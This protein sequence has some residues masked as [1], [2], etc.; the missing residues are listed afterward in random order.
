MPRTGWPNQQAA[1]PLLKKTSLDFELLGELA[2]RHKAQRLV[3]MQA[4]THQFELG[5]VSTENRGLKI[6][7]I[8]FAPLHQV[9]ED[10]STPAKWLKRHLSPRKNI[11]NIMASLAYL[12]PQQKS[13]IC[14]LMCG[15]V[16]TGYEDVL[17][18][19]M[20]KA[21]KTELEIVFI[22]I[23]IFSMPFPRMKFSK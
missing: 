18:I 9:Y 7:A 10:E 5:R 17:T 21:E 3:L 23:P 15:E 4:D 14:I 2:S 19:T 16:E 22:K 13:Q 6:A 8:L 11:P 12:T 1:Y 20:K